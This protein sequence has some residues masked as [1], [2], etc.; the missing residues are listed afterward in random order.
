MKFQYILLL[1]LLLAADIFAY[2]EV[3]TLIRQPSDAA[4]ILGLV[5]LAILILVN[6]FVIRFSLSK[7]KA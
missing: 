4:V 3:T 2:T 5:L 7:L 1:G 6:F